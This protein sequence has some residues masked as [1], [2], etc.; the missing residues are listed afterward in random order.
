MTTDTFLEAQ[1]EGAAR[2]AAEIAEAERQQRERLAE[3][4]RDDALQ[5]VTVIRQDPG[6]AAADPRS[7][8]PSS[9]GSTSWCSIGASAQSS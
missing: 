1:G 5:R 2:L 4:L 6:E 7:C 9:A 3:A 8:S